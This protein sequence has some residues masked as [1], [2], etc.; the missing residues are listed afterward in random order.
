MSITTALTT[1]QLKDKVESELKSAFEEA[2]KPV[3]EPLQDLKSAGLS[4]LVKSV[5]IAAEPLLDVLEL[6]SETI[7]PVFEP[8]FNTLADSI[9]EQLPEI[10]NVVNNAM[11]QMEL[12]A[13][14][15]P[16]IVNLLPG[17]VSAFIT[18]TG[19]S[20]QTIIDFID[21][22]GDDLVTALMDISKVLINNWHAG[23]A[24][25]DLFSWE[26]LNRYANGG[27]VKGDED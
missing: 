7:A 12:L 6:L 24:F 16:G 17:I 10:Q 11:P 8:L 1:K 27:Y 21:E 15:I 26:G 3:A 20:W 4:S 19:F 9:Q 25:T 18:F 13:Q 5:N 14:Q 2:L 23:K 22:Y